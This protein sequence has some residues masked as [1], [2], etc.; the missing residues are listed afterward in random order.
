MPN[1]GD[2]V[3]PTNFQRLDSG[4]RTQE[5]EIK[6]RGRE[7]AKKAE[8]DSPTETSLQA[9][10]ALEEAIVWGTFQNVTWLSSG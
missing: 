3:L 6:E 2:N 1:E 5:S 8:K 9:L 7:T 4:V 10:D